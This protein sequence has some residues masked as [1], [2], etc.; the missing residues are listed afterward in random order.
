M[1]PKREAKRGHPQSAEWILR[2]LARVRGPHHPSGEIARPSVGIEQ[3]AGQGVESHGVEGEVA[4]PGRLLETHARVHHDLET[5]VARPGLRFP[6]RQGDFQGEASDAEHGK[7]PADPAD[8][9]EWP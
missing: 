1:N 2:E 7:G 3:L 6:A 4:A 5:Q 9:S 8:P